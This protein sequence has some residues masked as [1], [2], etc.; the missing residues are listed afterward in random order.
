M[1]ATKNQPY[2][3]KELYDYVKDELKKRGITNDRIGEVAYE[4][5][6]DRLP[7]VTVEQFG[8]ELNNVLKKR[9]VLNNLAVGFA[10][11]D[12]AEAK[13][14]PPA[15][16]LII[17]NDLGAFGV[18]ESLALSISHMYGSI[19]DTNYGYADHMKFGYA[20]E[21]D[22]DK[23][24]VNTF[25]DDLFL[26]LCSAVCARFAHGSVLNMQEQGY[27]ESQSKPKT[28]GEGRKS[29][30]ADHFKKPYTKMIPQDTRYRH[31]YKMIHAILSNP[32]EFDTVIEVLLDDKI[33]KRNRKMRI[34][35]SSFES[36]LPSYETV[37]TIKEKH[38]YGEVYLI[39]GTARDI[40][41]Q[42]EKVFLKGSALTDA[43]TI[44]KVLVNLYDSSKGFGGNAWLDAALLYVSQKSN[45][46]TF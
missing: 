7:D 8:N 25:S 21:L 14:L 24:S 1:V 46:I 17:E 6:H 38:P 42:I 18:D 39:T 34:A 30:Y 35:S 27:D 43:Q 5:Q 19:S 23:G 26:A 16:Q 41:R 29:L 15:L 40:C 22:N 3:D 28:Q 11:D 33:Q 9:E 13:Q 20:K 31:H 36:V 37:Y 45:D 2:P 10:L 12:L 32:R 44:Q 4:L